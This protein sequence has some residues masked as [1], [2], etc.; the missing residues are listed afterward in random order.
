MKQVCRVITTAIL[1]ISSITGF[2]QSG[3]IVGE[4]VPDLAVQK[5][6]NHTGTQSRLRGL[7]SKLT[8]IDFF[9]TWCVPCLRALPKLTKLKAQYGNELSVVLVSN[10]SEAQL[11]KFLRSRQ[12]F[13]FPVV[14]DE[15]S[16]WNA[17][18]NPPSLPYTVVLG[19]R[20]NILAVTEA[21]DITPEA[22]QQ[23]LTRSDAE[24]SAT[25]TRTITPQTPTPFMNPSAK[26]NNIT[27][28]LSQDFLYAAKTGEAVKNY[29]DQL[30]ELDY[31]TLKN[32]LITND[33]KKAFWINIYN[34][35]S[36]QALLKNPDRYK[37]RSAFFKAKE[38]NIAGKRFSLDD[39]EHG[40]LRHSKIKWLLGY[41]D[42]L[43]PGKTEKELRVNRLDYRIHFALN[44][45]AKSCPPIAYY[46]DRTLDT[47]LDLATKAYLTSEVVY[48][49]AANVANVPKLMSWFRA[50]FGGK[51][52]AVRILKKYG[53]LPASADP[54]IRF[55]A[56]DWNLHLNNFENL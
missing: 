45:G 35:Y 5:M 10:E 38:I 32:A 29:L 22:V 53:V 55:N 2:A 12:G 25:T 44:C 47:Q 13:T 18:F 27:V 46:N 6:L 37:D 16:T 24:T 52:G 33:E 49:S 50:D 7:Q 51:K 39:I 17:V 41:V 3:L 8:I 26:S 20:G 34:A 23:W 36:L 30:K 42:K 48:D 11:Q 28:Q 9:G 43:F 31:K 15:G 19:G 54:K 40:I 14:V 56:Y 4:T 21:E 1:F